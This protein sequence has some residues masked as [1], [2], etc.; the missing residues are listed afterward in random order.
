[1]N[2]RHTVGLVKKVAL[3]EPPP[4]ATSPPTV[5]ERESAIETMCVSSFGFPPERKIERLLTPA[6]I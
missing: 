3:P 4:R 5:V 2:W 6:T 1:M